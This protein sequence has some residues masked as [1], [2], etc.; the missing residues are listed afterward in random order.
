MS[1]LVLLFPL[2][3]SIICGVWNKK[4]S[5]QSASNV[6]CISMLFST[7]VA[8][9]IF[10]SYVLGDASPTTITV[11]KWFSID[12]ICVNWAV[13]V[14]QLTAL[15]FM[16]VTIVST[17]VHIYSI[18]YMHDDENLPRFMSYLSLF[19]FFMLL[20]VSANNFIQLFCGWEGV[21]LCSYLLIGFWYNKPAPC[22][23]SIKAFV[24]N[25]VGDFAFI[26]G[27]IA[28]IYYCNTVTFDAVF[29]HAERLT[30]ISIL[31]LRFSAMDL[32][33][34]LLFIGAMGK[35]AQ[36]GLHVWLPDAMEGP[37]PV[38]ALIHAA[39]M[40][41]AGVFLVA[42][43]SFLFEYSPLVLQIMA[44][45]GAVT[46]LFAAT[47][48]I[49]QDDIKKII[50]Y[51]TCSQLGYMFIACGVSAYQ[52]AIFHLAT[53]AFF[54]AL[55]F[56][57]AGS[58]IHATHEQDITKLGGLRKVMPYTYLLF[59][60]G[61]LAIIGIFPFAGY[62]SKDLILE[63]AFASRESVGDMIFA[64]GIIAAF[65][66]ACYSIKLIILVFHG[67]T[68]MSASNF[69][70]AHESPKVMLL[71]LTLLAVGAVFA[72]MYGYYVMHIGDSQSYFHSS[73]VYNAVEVHALPQYIKFMPLIVGCIG[74]LSVAISI[75]TNYKPN[76]NVGLI[77]ALLKNKYYFDEIYDLTVVRFIKYLSAYY[78]ALDKNFIDKYGPGG[79]VS[80][81]TKC[82]SEIRK[83]QT[84]YIFNYS[85][86]IIVGV[87]IVMSVFLVRYI[88]HISELL[89]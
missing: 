19:T 48:A 57:C 8:T 61:S 30:T 69:K 85:L 28:I 9:D 4:L 36:I 65:F 29:T 76:K 39:T 75:G 32:I 24:V 54:K 63:S 18:G 84:G 40:V 17:V 81:I 22:A 6:A 26:L 13:Y 73:I 23:A 27:I 35:S 2:I 79:A 59:W 25:R 42:R 74:M 46:C 45:V 72:G 1:A 80:V 43:C 88:T 14:D 67:N 51:S 68:R 12:D 5:H 82:A 49:M 34:I 16:V 58:V 3:S 53:H 78:A 89:R 38:S 70:H 15:M 66:T 86:Y 87:I 33:C 44:I 64:L 71:P 56:L 62:Y 20:L 10:V 52:A 37:T 60:L 77:G 7:I 83:I 41:T 31:D 55:L 21:G 11:A 50:A 47:I